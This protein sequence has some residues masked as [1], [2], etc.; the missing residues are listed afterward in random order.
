MAVI[1]QDGHTDGAPGPRTPPLPTVTAAHLAY[2]IHTSG[3]SGAPK[4]VQVTHGSLVNV[5]VSVAERT[6]LTASDVML[7]VTTVCFDIAGL[8]LLAPLLVGGHVVVA[9][10]AETVDGTALARRLAAD[11]VTAMQATPATWQL[12]LDAGW[13]PAA[14]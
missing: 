4:A 11:G 10:R 12:L 5:L 14:G 7:A 9:D 8:E 6:P 13:Q 3:S 2:V 1:D